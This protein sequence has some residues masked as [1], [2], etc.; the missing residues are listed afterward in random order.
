MLETLGVLVLG[1]RTNEL[2]AFYTHSSGL[3]LE[4]RV[5]SPEDAAAV[6]KAHWAISSSGVLL[7]NPIPKAHALD[8]GAVE[9]AI[10]AGLADAQRA[11]V[12]GKALTPHLL[13][14]LARATQ[15]RSLQANRVLALN[16]AAFAADVA[17]QLC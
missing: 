13:A 1:V 3:P 17:V 6:L 7:A 4:H 15:K 10:E 16:N 5:D 9:R 2:P 12:R 11:N 14:Y 8:A